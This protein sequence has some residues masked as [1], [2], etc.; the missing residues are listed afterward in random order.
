MAKHIK[1]DADEMLEANAAR[2]DAQHESVKQ[3]FTA[4]LSQ[5]ME[6][7]TEERAAFTSFCELVGL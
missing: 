2:F 3:E 4:R 5:M 6:L 1:W 7:H